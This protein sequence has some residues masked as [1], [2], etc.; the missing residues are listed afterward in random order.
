MPVSPRRS[1][2]VATALLAFCGVAFPGVFTAFAATG[3]S[4]DSGGTYLTLS[5]TGGE[6]M[7]LTATGSVGI[8]TT[9]PQV[10]LD[11]GGK[12]DALRLSSGTAAQRP[13]AS[14]GMIRY[15][16]TNNTLEG[17]VGGTAT[18]WVPYAAVGR[19][20]LTDGATI[21]VDWTN[22]NIQYVTLGGNRTFTFANPLDGARYILVI[23]QDATGS[24]TITWPATV[25]WGG[26]TAP[27][28]TTTASKTDYIG[29]IYNGV[30]SKYDGIALSQNF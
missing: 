12:T 7:R 25:R 29:F 6:V 21:A 27:T 2:V 30:D 11:L 20:P 28:L 15:N 14:T 5:S 4:G 13:T 23:K 22:S 19:Y 3:V 17:Y 10:T 1:L 8:G 9:T 18:G 16:T 26:G 24:R